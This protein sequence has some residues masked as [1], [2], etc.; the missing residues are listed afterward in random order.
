M[1]FEIAVHILVDA[2]NAFTGIYVLAKNPRSI[3]HRSFFVFALGI[4]GWSAGILL[5]SLT[6]DF[7]SITFTLWSGEIVVLGFVIFAAVF[8]DDGTDNMAAIPGTP[9]FSVVRASALIPLALLFLLSPFRLILSGATLSA[10]GYLEPQ[11]G[12]LFPFFA[13]T[14]AAYIVWGL[15]RLAA[16]Y[17]AREGVARVQLR[18]VIA[19][20]GIFLTGAFLFDVLLPAFHIF[21]LNLLGPLCSVALIACAAYAMVRHELMDI[22]VVVKKGITYALVIIATVVIFVSLEFLIE[23]FIDPNDEIVDIFAAAVGAL[24]FS[25]LKDF[26]A[27][28]TDKVFFRGQ[29]DYAA[30]VRELGAL[31]SNTIDLQELLVSLADF[32]VRTTKPSQVVFFLNDDKE[33]MR[34]FGLSHDAKVS[35]RVDAYRDLARTFMGNGG[36]PIFFQEKSEKGTRAE[37]AK[38]LGIAAVIPFIAKGKVNGVMLLGEKL[39]DDIYRA[40]DIDLLRVVAHQAGIAVENARLYD[41]VRR[42][43]EELEARVRERT[44]KLRTMQEAQSKFLTD[45]SHE[46]QTPV[47]ILKGNMDIMEQKRKGDRKTALRAMGNAVTRMAQMVDHLLAIARLNFSKEK[48]YKERITVDNFL[49][50]IYYDCFALAESKGVTLSYSASGPL[51][52]TADKE[53]VRAVILNLLSNAL[54]HTPRGGKIALSAEANRGRVLIA[55]ADT[56]SGI[57]QEDL[58]LIFERFYRIEGD[59]SPGTGLGLDI[60]KKIIEAHGGVITVESEIGKGSRFTISLP[61][62]SP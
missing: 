9:R 61:A 30:S 8:P 6:G 39:S 2:L 43:R 31:T 60:V 57:A 41:E 62:E 15:W 47:A 27:N 4:V 32:L 18:Y 28:L 3:V 33:G 34:A 50:E 35:P 45:V 55:V 26:F 14:L 52:L 54:K 19:G 29:Y 56:G 13:L 22:Q 44:E 21:T 23:K 37:M 49:E 53:K 58:P 12:P 10:R 51:P 17:R 11:N 5:V 40:K 20:A 36:E 16:K 24:F 38:K 48:L 46:L 25:Q 1:A 42:D 7:F 59:P